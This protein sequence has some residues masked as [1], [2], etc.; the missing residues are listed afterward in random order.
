MKS[1][2][3]ENQTKREGE[4]KWDKVSVNAVPHPGHKRKSGWG[5]SWK[6]GARVIKGVRGRKIE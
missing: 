2:A 6:N 3:D 5:R 1:R 4:N